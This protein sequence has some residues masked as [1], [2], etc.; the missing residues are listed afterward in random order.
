[1]FHNGINLVLFTSEDQTEK[2]GNREIDRQMGAKPVCHGE[3]RPE[4]D[5]PGLPANL[6]SHSHQWYLEHWELWDM[7]ERVMSGIQAAQI[8]FLRRVADLSLRDRVRSLII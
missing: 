7:T 5:A 2:L 3:A 6:C 4:G 8:S 1:M